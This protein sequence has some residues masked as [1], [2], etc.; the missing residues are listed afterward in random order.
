[1]TAWRYGFILMIPAAFAQTTVKVT[2][3]PAVAGAYG[4]ASL[5]VASSTAVPASMEWTF[6]YSPTD[7]SNVRLA[8]GAAMTSAG[9]SLSCATTTGQVR[10]IA[11]GLNTKLIPNGVLA[12]ATFNVSARAA[13]TSPLQIT[14]LAATSALAKTISASGSGATLSISPASKVSRLT[15]SPTSIVTPASSVCTVTLVATAVE[16][17][18]VALGLGAGSA[19]VTIPTSVIVP[20]GALSAPFTVSAGLVAAKST[21]ILVSSYN[22]TSASFA[23]TLLP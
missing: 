12:T 23:L 15:C 20:A 5:S 22:G 4:T 10:C 2:P 13:S 6:A 7:L 9:K 18:G 3:G 21:A 14:G 16:R 11:W 8:A 17:V 1:M 19:K